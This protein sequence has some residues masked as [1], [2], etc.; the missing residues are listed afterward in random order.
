MATQRMPPQ[1]GENSENIFLFI[2]NLVGNFKS[3]N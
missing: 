1:D 3:I 2:P